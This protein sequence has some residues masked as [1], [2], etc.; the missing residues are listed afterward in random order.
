MHQ[1]EKYHTEITSAFES[2]ISA[3]N[4]T[5][6]PFYVGSGISKWIYFINIL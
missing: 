6:K 4:Q 2:Y 1:E 5:L 3:G